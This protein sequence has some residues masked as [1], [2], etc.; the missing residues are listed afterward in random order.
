[1]EN[2]RNEQMIK[3]FEHAIEVAREELERL[4]FELADPGL[5]TNEEFG[6]QL[7]QLKKVTKELRTI[8][9]E[10]ECRT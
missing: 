10:V 8:A 1:M 7:K 6:Y 2:V 3:N 5:E 9:N 4:E